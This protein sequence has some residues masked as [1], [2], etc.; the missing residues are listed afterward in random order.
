MENYE[1]VTAT[2]TTIFL[3]CNLVNLVSSFNP[4]TNHFVSLHFM[5]QVGEKERC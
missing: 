1:A 3:A 2:T 5:L 4:L